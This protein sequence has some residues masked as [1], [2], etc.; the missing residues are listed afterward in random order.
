MSLCER[1]YGEGKLKLDAPHASSIP[2]W[3][4]ESFVKLVLEPKTQRGVGTS[5]KL[6]KQEFRLELQ[7][8]C[9]QFVELF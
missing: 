4:Q 5:Q 2:E 9:Q 1:H 6:Q 8:V 7:V 3:F